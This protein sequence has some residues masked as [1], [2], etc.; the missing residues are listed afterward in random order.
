MFVCIKKRSFHLKMV[1]LRVWLVAMVTNFMH[2]RMAGVLIVM[3][4]IVEL[5]I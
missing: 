4:G 5:D 2:V 3:V 1:M